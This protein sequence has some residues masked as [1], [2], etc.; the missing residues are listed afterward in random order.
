M[1]ERY[2]VRAGIARAF[3]ALSRIGLSDVLGTVCALGEMELLP[4]VQARHWLA[5]MAAE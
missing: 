1:K 4:L 5:R 3:D 2:C